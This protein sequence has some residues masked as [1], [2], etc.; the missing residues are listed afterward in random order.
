MIKMTKAEYQAK[1]G[2]LPSTSVSSGGNLASNIWSDLSQRGTNVANEITNNQQN[3]LLSGIKATAQVFG[4]IGDVVGETAKSI[5]P[6][7]TKKAGDI[8]KAGFNKVTDTISN[9]NLFKQASQYPE[10]T[11]VLE[12]FLSGGGSLGD[13]ANNILIAKG[14]TDTL[15]KGADIAGKTL[16]PV[17][18]K[19]GTIIKNTGEASTGLG[20]EMT[21]PTKQALMSYEAQQPSLF[22]RVKNFFTG[23][24]SV[25][26]KPIT[27]ANTA[28]RHGLMGTEWQMGVQAQKASN[29]LFKGVIQPAL[30]TSKDV[31]SKN[32]F[33]SNLKKRII[34]ENPD[35]TR[36]NTLLNALESFSSDYK[37]VSNFGLSKLQEYKEGW[38]KF[39]PEKAYRGQPIAGGLNDVRNM[40]A[41]EARKIIYEKLGGNI[42][43][44]Y[45][46][47]GNLK[48]ITEF[49]QKS[50]DA[51]RAKG[52]SKQIWEAVLDKTITPV[53]TAAGQVLYRLGSSLELVGKKGAKTVRDIIQH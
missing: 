28:A 15:Q 18:N 39:I 40:A 6:N 23:Q 17:L 49:A 22:G 4:G 27:E 25:G 20:L 10:H 53:S 30:D 41:Q 37:K 11:K 38:A 5:A 52:L 45:I 50:V 14:G 8:S 13:I 21:A 35:L 33:F 42:K 47:Y 19:A 7:L 48:S 34:S 31:V 51:L 46:D 2:S 1:Y 43:T 26:T 24:E 29:N 44:A 36:R 32:N 12:N 9:T 16:Q 3:P